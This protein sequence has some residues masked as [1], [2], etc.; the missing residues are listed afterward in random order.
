MLHVALYDMQSIVNIVTWSTSHSFYF[1]LILE[2]IVYNCQEE[3]YRSLLRRY[4][5]FPDMRAALT[6]ASW[7]A[8]DLGEA[9]SNWSRVEDPRCVITL[10][11]GRAHCV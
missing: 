2:R 4:P 7:R 5:D 8:G 9:E 11:E 6:A 1:F 3:L 10:T